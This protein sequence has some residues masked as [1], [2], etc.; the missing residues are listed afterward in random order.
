MVCYRA[1]EEIYNTPP[2]LMPLF[3]SRAGSTPSVLTKDKDRILAY[4]LTSE[5]A[6]QLR[7]AGVRSGQSVPG[8]V[9]A[10]L[11]R[12]GQAHTPQIAESFGQ[13]H[14]DFSDDETSN[15]LPRCDMTGVTGDVHLVVYG[16]ANGVVAKLLGTEPRFLL[17]KVTSLSVPVTILSLAS[18]GQLEAANKLPPKTGA[19]TTL[20]VW[21]RQ[22]LESSWE[23]LQRANNHKQETLPLGGT[24]DDLP[25]EN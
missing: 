20:R 17:Q 7:T 5:G 4:A 15:F 11:I 21:F 25:L 16:E 9:L 24:G 10:S 8:R 22:D 18:L 6:K 23:K 13:H 19:A 3:I 12:S 1:E 2:R 14:F